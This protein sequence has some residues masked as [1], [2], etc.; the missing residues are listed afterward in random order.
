MCVYMHVNVCMHLSCVCSYVLFQVFSLCIIVKVC[1]IL[2]P[3]CMLF[4]V[5]R[6]VGYNEEDS[7]WLCMSM[8]SYIVLN[9]FIASMHNSIHWLFSEKWL[10][11]FCISSVVFSKVGI[12]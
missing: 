3:K 6:Y 10:T 2:I 5:G 4:G 12:P 1:Q 11:I 7:I 8:G 9:Y